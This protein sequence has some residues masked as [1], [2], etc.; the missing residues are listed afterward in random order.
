VKPAAFLGIFTAF[1]RLAWGD[2]GVLIPSTAKQPDARVLS[3]D[4]MV[5]D[6]AIDNGHATVRIRQ[7]YAN[8]TG[9]PIEGNYAFTLPGRALIS[10]FA[11]WD[12]TTRIPGVILERK[13][14]EEIYADI[15]MQALDPGLL[16]MGER[17]ADEERRS[18]LFT[19]RV[20]PIPA[21]GT[22]R[23]EIEY[24][25][26]LPVEQGEVFFAIPIHPDVYRAQSAGRLSIH[27][28]LTS[29]HAMQNFEFK[30][31]NY[32]MKISQ[33]TAKIVSASFDGQ[34]VALTEDFALKY[35]LDARKNSLETQI[36]RDGA[37]PNS[38]AP[39]FFEASL[40]LAMP[41]TPLNT[42]STSNAPST[43]R[44]IVALFDASLS[45]QWEK[46]ERSFRAV[47]SLL[48]SLKPTDR[49]NLLVYNEKIAPFAPAP[50]DAAPDAIEKALAFLRAQQLRGGTN[51]QMALDAALGQSYT[52]DPYIVLLGDLGATRGILQNGKLAQWYA[53]K[54]KQIAEAQRP[55]TYVFATGDDANL[56]LG[57]M[58][59]QN[60]GVFEWVRSTEPVDFKL[61]AFLSKIGH[62]PVDRLSLEITPVANV[63]LVYPLEDSVFPG[64]VQTWVG[65]YKSPGG[66]ATFI[67][68]SSAGELAR[69]TAPLAAQNTDHANLPREWAKARVDALLDKIDREG[70][71]RASIDEIIKLS[72]KYKFV[73]PYT[74]F[75]AAPRALLRPRLIRP[76]DPVLRVRTDESIESVIAMFPFG[77]VKKLRYLND[78][79][80]WQT[81]FLA[82][83]DL[84]D[85]TYQVRLLLRDRQGR[86]FR[87]SKTFVIASKAPQVRVKLDRFQFRRGDSVR[88]QVNASDTTRTIVARMFGAAPAYLKWNAQMGSN[89]GEL[90]VPASL[91][92]GRYQ[93]TVTAEDFAHNIGSGEVEIEILP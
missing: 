76:G 68:R 16:Q 12:D 79:D 34:A 40:L 7:I 51:V 45:M 53:A 6:V 14:A 10:D 37:G 36:Y 91:P 2:A 63:D 52:N 93:V 72:R 27:L 50:V 54:W 61:N 66:S 70:E 77:P 19:A 38:S 57:R 89:T 80:I 84:A 21:W 60:N 43:P 1:L 83:Q 41:P 65:E 25:E 92:A 22:K 23:I 75:L 59:A 26:R 3:L 46:L 35:A 33:K 18:S 67:A 56:P 74:S 17:D 20:A 87:E 28:N 48:R 58:L 71:D 62:K 13:R 47:E 29:A 44:T 81:R 9:A 15:R 85:G 64:S 31:A 4:E 42:A 49:F 78:E 39:G 30:S 86:V 82:P 5:I 24:Q 73:T 55:R 69:A 8:H 11:V 32:T 90:L 88:L